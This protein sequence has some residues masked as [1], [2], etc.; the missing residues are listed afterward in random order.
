V[1][2]VIMPAYNAS[3]FI[4]Q[5]LDSILRQTY[6]DFE[7]IVVDDG[8]ID[9]T[10]H[11]LQDYA[12][13]DPRFTV[14]QNDHGGACKARNTAIAIARHPWIASLDADDVALPNRFERQLAAAS[15]QPEVVVWGS[16]MQQINVDDKVIG[17]IRQG[18]NS[19]A[20]FNAID[21]SQRT[22]YVNNSSSMFRRDLAQQLGGFDERLKAGQDTELWDRMAQHGPIVILPEALGQYRIHG[23]SITAK[24]FTEQYK[25][26]SF[27]RARNLAQKHGQTLTLEQYMA[28]Y[29]D[30]PPMRRFFRSM[31]INGQR[32]YRNAGVLLAEK[33]YLPAV[34]S[35]ALAFLYHPGFA[36]Q[37][38]RGRLA[39]RRLV[40]ST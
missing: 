4:R 35:M 38:I 26:H 5:A 2:S 18:P 31:S 33:R 9:D 7:V 21:R 25:V 3:R 24:R 14:I 11:I 13:R 22:L 28:T 39:R 15:Q 6:Q 32:Y 40:K 27:L 23:T 34:G 20:E 36:T 16:Y 37:R 19:V 30:V 10:L 12:R 17:L 29:D 1:I 8:S